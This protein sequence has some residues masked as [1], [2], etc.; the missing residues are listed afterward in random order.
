MHLHLHLSR[1]YVQSLDCNK[2]HY[3]YYGVLTALGGHTNIRCGSMPEDRLQS[4]QALNTLHPR[5]RF[6][7]DTSPAIMHY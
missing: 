5:D 3:Q 1:D 2:Y 4:E 7:Y 6:Q